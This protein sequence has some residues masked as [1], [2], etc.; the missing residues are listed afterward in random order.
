MLLCS[1]E[2]WFYITHRMNHT[3]FFYYTTH[4]HHHQNVGYVYMVNNSDVDIWE[5]LTQVVHPLLML[6]TPSSR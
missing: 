1:H 4:G 5:L 3:E 2:F 6:F